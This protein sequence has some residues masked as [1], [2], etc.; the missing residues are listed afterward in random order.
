MGSGFG[1]WGV[2]EMVHCMLAD[3]VTLSSRGDNLL[4]TQIAYAAL[5]QRMK[6]ERE[7][8]PHNMVFRQHRALLGNSMHGQSM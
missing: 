6:A 4:V 1:L 7:S 3:S 2:F 5:E 8:Q